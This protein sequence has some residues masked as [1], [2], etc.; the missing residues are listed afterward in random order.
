MTTL[1]QLQ[2][3]YSNILESSKLFSINLTKVWQTLLGNLYLCPMMCCL[4]THR[5]PPARQ[6]G[7]DRSSA[8]MQRRD[9]MTQQCGGQENL[10][11]V[12]TEV[13][14]AANCLSGSW[15]KQHTSHWHWSLLRLAVCDWSCRSEES[16]AYLCMDPTSTGSV[17]IRLP[18]RF[19]SV[20]VAMSHKAAGNSER[21][22]LDRLR[23]RSLQNL[24]HGRASGEHFRWKFTFRVCFTPGMS[25]LRWLKLCIQAHPTSTSYINGRWVI[26]PNP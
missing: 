19:S 15:E 5:V 16:A 21:A 11:I 22:L 10:C 6:R 23:L 17:K 2:Y 18:D 24:K 7:H 4:C 13:W 14:R 3:K 1:T 26:E 25:K 9:Q 8:P 12:R 20:S